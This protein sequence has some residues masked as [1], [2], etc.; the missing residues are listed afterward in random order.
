L[1]RWSLN[2][3]RGQRRRPAPQCPS[4]ARLDAASLRGRKCSLSA[5][6]DCFAFLFGDQRHDPDREPVRVRHVDRDELNAS[7][8]Q[9]KQEMRVATEPVELRE[10]VRRLHVFISADGVLAWQFV[11][12]VTT[13]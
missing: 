9:P 13:D 8:L 3:E 5:L 7:L 12:F 10:L 2:R 11:R 6:A 1:P 4:G